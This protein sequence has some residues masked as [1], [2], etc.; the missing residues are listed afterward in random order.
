MYFLGN[1]YSESEQ[2][3]IG[4]SELWPVYVALHNVSGG[5]ALIWSG[6]G[7]YSLSFCTK[8]GFPLAFVETR[9]NNKGNNY[10]AFDFY[11]DP[12]STHRPN[13][14]PDLRSTNVKYIAN[15]VKKFDRSTVE[16]YASKGRDRL[17]KRFLDMNFNLAKNK[18]RKLLATPAIVIDNNLTQQQV[19]Q[20]VQLITCDIDRLAL[21][22]NLV[23]FCEENLVRLNR[24]R[25]AQAKEIEDYKMFYARPKLM[26]VRDICNGI[27]VAQL[28]QDFINAEV[29]TC[30]A[31]RFCSTQF[32]R[33]C[34]ERQ[35]A[36]LPVLDTVAWYPNVESLPEP[37]SK[38]V[39]TSLMMLKVHTGS[40][41]SF[42]DMSSV[43][44]AEWPDM[45]AAAQSQYAER[46]IFM[47]EI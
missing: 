27:V 22:P 14:K 20:I 3:A 4:R 29:E 44:N 33:L 42:P 1:K 28:N 46:D 11:H 9:Q 45:G 2:L 31:E 47:I 30:I 23:K 6:D 37:L 43:N 36:G 10:Y 7:N 19:M 40:A 25:A 35:R 38:S 39:T 8:E 21:D 32:M 24:E 5:N 16:Y 18:Y 13:G 17:I 26:I 34:N 15:K 12:L 41:G